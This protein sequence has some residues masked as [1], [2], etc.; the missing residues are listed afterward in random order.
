M[1]P[2]SKISTNLYHFQPPSWTWGG[3]RH[4]PHYLITLQQMRKVDVRWTAEEFCTIIS[5]TLPK[6]IEDDLI[7]Y[8]RI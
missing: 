7:K 6:E 2:C 3:W 1:K 5:I 4:G 8:E